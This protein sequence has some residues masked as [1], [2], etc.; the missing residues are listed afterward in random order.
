MTLC[1]GVHVCGAV[2]M[3]V[4]CWLFLGISSGIVVHVMW[5][6]GSATTRALYSGSSARGDL[7][8]LLLDAHTHH[9]E[10]PPDAAP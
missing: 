2:G 1:V 10:H 5:R 7:A 9:L 8:G 3:Q 6:L 4:L